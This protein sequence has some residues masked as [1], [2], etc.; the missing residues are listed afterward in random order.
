MEWVWRL[1]CWFLSS[2][3]ILSMMTLCLHRLYGLPSILRSF[4][5]LLAL[6]TSSKDKYHLTFTFLSRGG[7][8][9]KWAETWKILRCSDL[10]ISWHLKRQEENM[11]ATLLALKLCVLWLQLMSWFKQLLTYLKPTLTHTQQTV[12]IKPA[13]A[14]T[15]RDLQ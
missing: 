2:C 6:P 7:Y 1:K 14:S 15:C 13:Q 4:A 5:F 3:R 8:T 10:N 11:P 12:A 9:C